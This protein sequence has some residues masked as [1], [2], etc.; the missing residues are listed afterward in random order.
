MLDFH[1]MGDKKFDVA[2]VVHGRVG[3]ERIKEEVAKC[4]MLC[5]NCHRVLHY[6]EKNG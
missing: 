5:A 4:V 2:N 3:L 1:H 6:E